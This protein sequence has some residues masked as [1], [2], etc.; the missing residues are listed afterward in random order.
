MQSGVQNTTKLLGF[1]DCVYIDSKI[2]IAVYTF[3]FDVAYAK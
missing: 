3:L 2:S 1:L